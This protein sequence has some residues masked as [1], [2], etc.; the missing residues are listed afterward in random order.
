VESVEQADDLTI[1]F[2]L[3]PGIQ[4]SGDFGELT[5]EDV[6]FSIDRVADPAAQA[7][8]QAKWAS[9]DRVELEGTHAG[10]IILKEPFQPIWYTTICH[11]IASFVCKKAVE[12]AGGKIETQLPAVCGPYQVK[13]WLPKQ[14]TELELNPMWSG[15]RPDFHEIHLLTIEDEKA[16]ELAYQAGDIDLTVVSIDSLPRYQQ[17]LPE[18]TKL[19]MRPG[20]YWS[21]VGMNT[22]HPKL[23]DIRVRQA[24]QHAVDVDTIL[25]AAYAGIAPKAHGIVP[26]GLLGHRTTSAIGYDPDK[27]R[28]LLQEAGVSD[29]QLELKTMSKS[30]RVAAAEVIQANLAEVGIELTVSPVDEAT[31]WNLG[32]ESEGEDWKDLQLW[33]MRFGDAADPSQMAQWYVSSQ[34]GV[35]NWERW[36]DAEFDELFQKALGERDADKRAA[37]YIRMQEIMENTGAYVWLT[38]E[39]I[40]H[41]HR[42]TVEPAL[43]PDGL[44]FLP[45]FKRL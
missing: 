10:A 21:W 9:L 16:A 8:W 37:M 43:F 42:E 4:W 28:A 2:R 25:Q 14:R 45:S 31:F 5:A 12:A 27:A 35:W 40:P 3:K 19:V 18:Q 7:P 39:P 44:M 29:L 1:R 26:P 30:D 38:H 11:A 36:K 34:V 13:N 22:E 24:I 32:L 6:K 33:I 41:L 20:T 15:A 23:A 17:S